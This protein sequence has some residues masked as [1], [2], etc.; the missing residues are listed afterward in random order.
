MFAKF[1][2]SAY[3]QTH[4]LEFIKV[5]SHLKGS[6]GFAVPVGMFALWTVWPAIG[7]EKKA[8]IG[9]PMSAPDAAFISSKTQFMEDEVDKM[10]VL[11]S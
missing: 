2:K 10:P 1:T 6:L 8:A 3:F 9:I 5:V 7:D 11:R 4:K